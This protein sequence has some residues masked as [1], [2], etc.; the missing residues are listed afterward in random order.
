MMN[1]TKQTT[2]HYVC[3]DTLNFKHNK[4]EKIHLVM[5]C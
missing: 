5:D 2:N 3:M 1:N 4:N